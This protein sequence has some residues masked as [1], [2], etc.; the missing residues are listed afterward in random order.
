MQLDIRTE[1][2]SR[3]TWLFSSSLPRWLSWSSSLT[4]LLPRHM[5]VRMG[6]TRVRPS[7]ALDRLPVYIKNEDNAPMRKQ[8]G[9][10]MP[11]EG[12]RGWRW[13]KAFPERVGRL[14]QE[15]LEHLPHAGPRPHRGAAGQTLRGPY[16]DVW[17][18]TASTGGCWVSTS[19]PYF[20]LVPANMEP[21]A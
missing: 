17:P 20:L 18:G 2:V 13:E 15:A 10:L 5:P 7:P 11:Y 4:R 3:E 12:L 16:R 21:V 6:S 8:N 19:R 14:Y 1:P 9:S